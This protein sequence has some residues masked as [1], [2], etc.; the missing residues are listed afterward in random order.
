[1]RA[2]HGSMTS[3]ESGIAP[4]MPMAM[5]LSETFFESAACCNR[6]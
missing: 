2:S 5:P 6:V 4:E 3:W 1:V